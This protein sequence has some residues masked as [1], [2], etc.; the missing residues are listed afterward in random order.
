MKKPAVNIESIVKTN[1]KPEKDTIEHTIITTVEET[2][3]EKRKV[4]NDNTLKQDFDLSARKFIDWI[5]SIERILD[6]RQSYNL[7]PNDLQ[8]IVQVD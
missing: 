1:S 2:T 6:D 4:S 5:D 7:N 8:Q 3:V